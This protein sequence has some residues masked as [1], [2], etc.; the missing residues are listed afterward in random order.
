M[1]GADLLQ[2]RARALGPAY[3]LFYEQPVHLVRG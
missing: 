3:R 1:G 2:R